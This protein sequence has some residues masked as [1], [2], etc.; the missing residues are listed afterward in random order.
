MLIVGGG[1]AGLAAAVALARHRIPSLVLEA[2]TRR[3]RSDK[4]DVLHESSIRLLEKWGLFEALLAREPVRISTFQVL[5]E[6]GTELLRFDF[7][8]DLAAPARVLALQHTQIEELLEA[9]AVSTGYVEVQRGVT[10]RD[11]VSGKGRVN[12][13]VTAQRTVTADLVI[14][15]HGRFGRLGRRHF[16]PQ[17]QHDY[18]VRFYN[19]HGR[20]EGTTHTSGTYVLGKHGLLVLVPLPGDEI[21]IGVQWRYRKGDAHLDAAALRTIITQ[22]LDTFS[23]ERF[24]V[25]SLQAYPLVSFLLQ[26]FWTPGAA[27]VGDAAHTVHP[28]G[29]QGMNLA[30]QDAETLAGT[31][32]NV[33]ATEGWSHPTLDRALDL[34]SRQRIR[35]VRP[36][37][38]RTHVLGVLGG[39]EGRLSSFATRHALQFLDHLP[40]IRRRLFARVAEVR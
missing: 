21:R 40:R 1:V 34:Y 13:V 25:R 14:L 28:A 35:E 32:A 31:L 19:L 39:F 29:G 9:A 30:F 17:R 22:R 6:R 2:R 38:R 11:L 26:S 24:E 15:A 36:V 37:F 33:T 10:V 12:G 4:G 20:Y 3:D 16:R 8:R 7:V 23:A 18:S 5:D 27:V